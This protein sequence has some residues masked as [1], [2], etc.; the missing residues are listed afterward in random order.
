MEAEVR[1]SGD[2][3]SACLTLEKGTLSP[4]PSHSS[5]RHPT[6]RLSSTDA[7]DNVAGDF[8]LTARFALRTS[9]SLF[10]LCS[11]TL[12]NAVD[13]GFGAAAQR[14]VPG[15]DVDGGVQVP[16]NLTEEEAGGVFV[17]RAQQH[18]G[19]AGLEGK[20]LAPDTTALINE[21]T[22]RAEDV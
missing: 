12:G 10:W 19:G 8:I 16:K 6:C 4:S 15:N 17:A 18:D 7:R 20:Q 2:S 13:A 14:C 5:F 22:P 11:V 21:L 1:F 3:S 9:F